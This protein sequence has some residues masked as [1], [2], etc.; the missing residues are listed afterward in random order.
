MTNSKIFQYNFVCDTCTCSDL[1]RGLNEFLCWH[2]CRAPIEG[3]CG[4]Y[5]DNNHNGVI[6][7]FLSF[8]HPGYFGKVGM[9]YFHLTKNQYYCPVINVEQLWS[10][11]PP[12]V[13]NEAEKKKE[14]GKYPVL[15]LV[16]RVS[17]TPLYCIGATAVCPDYG[18]A[19]ILE[20]PQ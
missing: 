18:N 6:I 16:Q 14:E 7:N 1:K 9:R 12:K 8:S 3:N 2:L 20:C 19:L 10:L 15:D 11:V 13:A 4:F 17:S 5:I